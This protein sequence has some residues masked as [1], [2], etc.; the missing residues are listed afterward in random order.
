MNKNKDKYWDRMHRSPEPQS[1]DSLPHR[2]IKWLLR[3]LR[4]YIIRVVL[5]NLRDRGLLSGEVRNVLPPR[6][7]P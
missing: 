5:N 4:E 3:P 7:D 1:G 2:F 6:R